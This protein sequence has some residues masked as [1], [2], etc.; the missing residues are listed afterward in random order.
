MFDELD[1]PAGTPRGD[2]AGVLARAAARR[3]R[4]AVTTVG[5]GVALSLVA[6]LVVLARPGTPDAHSLREADPS[7]SVSA[8]ASPVPSDSASPE[9]GASSPAA[10]SP[11]ATTGPGSTPEPTPTDGYGRWDQ[12][13]GKP[14]WSTGFT[15]C[16]PAP[17][18]PSRAPA[19]D[20]RLTVVLDQPSFRPQDWVSGTATIHNDG[21]RAVHV[22]ASSGGGFDGVLY[23][24]GGKPANGVF[25]NDGITHLDEDIPAGGTYSYGFDAATSTCGDTY[26][27]DEQLPAGDYTVAPV[28]FW[29]TTDG[30]DS[31]TW[32]GD[33]VPVTLDPDA[34]RPSYGPP[35]GAAPCWTDGSGCEPLPAT[36]ACQESWLHDGAP[37]VPRENVT[38]GVA[39][40]S[41]TVRSG[42][43]LTATATITN[44]GP[45]GQRLH[46][47][48]GIDGGVLADQSGAVSGRRQQS[49]GM[50]TVDLPPGAHATVRITVQTRAC[51][52]DTLGD[53][54]APGR[55]DVQAGVYVDGWG[56]WVPSGTQSVLVTP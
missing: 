2:L 13:D 35:S 41:A 54:V 40:D 49:A 4:R 45:D 37:F 33:R 9:P 5:S 6:G 1:D 18:G 28:L 8:T 11:A 53:G 44:T 14:G 20:L 24:A 21:D 26:A 16:S 3:Y 43:A 38:I 56:W 48:D 25:G 7:P 15:W 23:G 30:S 52:G 10:M 12:P 19:S 27:Q 42:D 17:G 22:Y 46:V 50:T 36:A 32:L 51:D 47:V 34:P 55:Y 31:G 39:L 29:E